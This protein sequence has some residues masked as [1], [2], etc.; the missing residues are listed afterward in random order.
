MRRIR[1]ETRWAYVFLLP[2][3]IGLLVFQLGP[4]VASL[5][6]SF[7]DFDLIGDPEFVGLGNYARM[8]Q[9]PKVLRAV[10]NTVYYTALHV[11]LSIALALALALMLN[12]ITGRAAGVFR[13]I[14]Y[15]PSM[16]PYVAVGVLFLFLLNGQAGMVNQF[17][18]LFGIEGP[19]WTTDPDWILPGI[20]L[21]S[22]WNLGS[23]TIILFA[24]LRNVPRELTEA[25]MID[26]AGR[27]QRFR[28]ITLPMISSAVF[29]VVIINTISA[30]QMF[31]QVYAM[32]FGNQVA[33]QSHGDAALF[34]V[35]YLFQQAFQFLHMGYASALAWVLF[36]VILVIT[37][38]QVKVGNRLV[39]YE[40]EEHAG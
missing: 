27:W 28:S 23:T 14:F 13:T 34:Y 3:L 40:A 35:A 15:L 11:P 6:L 25:A 20:V 31:D 29:F 26:G 37:L 4:M 1:P 24:A 30:L 36:L 7:T 38:I 17:L 9:D 21:M 16:T 18:G 32:F 2:W 39:Y 19:Q 8:A 33:Q 10:G 22:L 12:R 5:V